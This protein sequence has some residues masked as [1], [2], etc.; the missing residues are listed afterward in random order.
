MLLE[1]LIQTGDL[2]N[3]FNRKDLAAALKLQ[4]DNVIGDEELE[5]DV[6]RLF[7]REQTIAIA[8]AELAEEIGTTEVSLYLS[9]LA[10][11]LLEAVHLLASRTMQEKYGSLP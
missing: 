3:R 10:E 6:L 11:I 7:K 4:L 5:L 8:T 9:D 2:T 1:Q